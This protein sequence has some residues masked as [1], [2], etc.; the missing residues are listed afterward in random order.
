MYRFAILIFSLC[1]FLSCDDGEGVESNNSASSLLSSTTWQLERYT[2]LTGKTI[3]NATLN[4][5]AKLLYDLAFEFR[6]NKE[7]RA[8]EKS[9]KN[10]LNRGTWELIEDNQVID[11]NITAFKGKFK[12]VA[13]QNDKLVLEAN[14]ETFITGLGSAIRMDFKPL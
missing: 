6:T 2:D 5:S 8:Y 13:I 10:V 3:S 4:S 1:I 9:T 11:I 7:T 14:T 12:I